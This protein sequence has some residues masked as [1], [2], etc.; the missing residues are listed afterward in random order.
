[1]LQPQLLSPNDVVTGIEPMLRRLIG[2]DIHFVTVLGARVGRVRADPGQLEQVLMNLAVN[3]RDAMPAGGKLVIE[4]A[5]ADVDE[6]YVSLHPDVQPGPYVVLTVSDTGTGMDGGTLARIFEPFFTTKEPG[7]GTGLGL[8]TVYGIVEQS[9]GH[10]NV[11]SEPDRGSVFKICLPRLV[12]DEHAETVGPRTAEVEPAAGGSETVLVVEDDQGMREIARELLEE[13]GYRV[14]EGA[15]PDAALELA[16]AHDGPI[17]LVLTDVV[18]PGMNGPELA[19]QLASAWP[20]L[21]V[22]YMS[23]YPREIAGHHHSQL[24]PDTP[25]IQK[26][27]TAQ[28]LLRRVREALD[29]VARLEAST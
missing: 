19:T 18:M 29:R 17:H 27:F 21:A 4:T 12:E 16:R 24:G 14:L 2:E 3:A 5:N 15:D 26:P 6:S 1:V 9:G 7:K 13:A 10:V 22:L 23:G 25:L 28:T 11:Y 8:A 20:R